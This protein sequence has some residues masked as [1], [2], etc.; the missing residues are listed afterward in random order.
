MLFAI[1]ASERPTNR[2]AP[3]LPSAVVLF[4]KLFRTTVGVPAPTKLIPPP[5]TPKFEFEKITLSSIRALPA[6][7]TSMP[8]PPRPPW[9]FGSCPFRKKALFRTT[10]EDDSD[11]IP[12]APSSQYQF[13]RIESFSIRGAPPVRW[14]PPAEPPVIVNPR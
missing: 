10:G 1:S 6:P 12:P 2:M 9:Q 4:L 11:V 5:P 8:P 13:S 3:P 14:I 7:C